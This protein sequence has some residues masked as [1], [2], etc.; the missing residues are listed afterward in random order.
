MVT[1]S[2]L[3]HKWDSN[4]YYH[5]IRMNQIVMA[6]PQKFKTGA[7]PSDSLVLSLGLSLWEWG[8]TP[9]Q[10]QLVYS[11]APVDWVSLIKENLVN[12]N[13]HFFIFFF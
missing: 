13:L 8:L 6:I 1:Y 7:S 4:R 2:Y 10:R 5:P 3:T 11:S 12:I 9:L